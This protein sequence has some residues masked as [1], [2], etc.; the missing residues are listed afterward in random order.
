MP[1][2][3]NANIAK[4]NEPAMGR[5]ASAACA[6]VSMSRMPLHVTRRLGLLIEVSVNGLH[7]IA[8]VTGIHL[9][10]YELKLFKPFAL[11]HCA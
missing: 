3:P 4:A 8:C 11:P 7:A 5:S 6:D 9:Q 1:L 2:I 10:F